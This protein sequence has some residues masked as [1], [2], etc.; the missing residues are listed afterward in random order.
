MYYYYHY[1]YYQCHLSGIIIFWFYCC[2]FFLHEYLI[3]LILT[4]YFININVYIYIQM[5]LIQNRQSNKQD[6]NTENSLLRNTSQ[7][8]ECHAIQREKHK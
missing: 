5:S 6:I 4:R 2:L 7:S 1:N 3:K 8:Q